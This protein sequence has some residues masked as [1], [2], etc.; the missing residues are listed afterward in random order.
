MNEHYRRVPISAEFIQSAMLDA[1]EHEVGHIIVAHHFQSRVLG[2]AVGFVPD[3]Q[4]MFLQALYC[5][6][7]WTVRT[8]CVVKAAG[9]AADRLYH[10]EAHVYGASFDLR[11]IQEISGIASFDPY[12]GIAK[13][14]LGYYPKQFRCITNGLRNVLKTTEEYTLER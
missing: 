6:S 3:Q 4:R 2:I 5:H 8:Q 10:G 1:V 9:P 12:I 13:D 14:I 7:N 11:D